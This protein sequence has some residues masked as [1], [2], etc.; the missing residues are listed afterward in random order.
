MNVPTRETLYQDADVELLCDYLFNRTKIT[1][2][3]NF[4]D[5]AWTPTKFKRYK[6]IFQRLLANFRDKRYTEVY[7]T[8]FENDVKAQK[9]IALFGFKEFDRKQGLVLMKREV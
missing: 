1:L 5:G 9:L 3:L 8:P 4:N 2:H 6:Q 7:A